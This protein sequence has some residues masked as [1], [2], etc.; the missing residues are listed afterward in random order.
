MNTCCVA[1]VVWKFSSP[2]VG[3][4]RPAC[5]SAA[6]SAWAKPQVPPP[7]AGDKDQRIGLRQRAVVRDVPAPRCPAPDEQARGPEQQHAGA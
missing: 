6:C 5:S 1:A 4:R 7:L 2:V 3:T